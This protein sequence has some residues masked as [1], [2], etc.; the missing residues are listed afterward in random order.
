[1]VEGVLRNGGAPQYAVSDSGTLVYIPGTE[2][3][4]SSVQRTLVWVDR[5]GK[6]EPLAAPLNAYSNPQISPDG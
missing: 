5:N 2:I 4:A 3:A 1:M 6:E